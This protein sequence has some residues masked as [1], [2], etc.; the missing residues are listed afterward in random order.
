M[1]ANQQRFAH[2]A[3]QDILLMQIMLIVVY[4]L[5]QLNKYQTIKHI[6]VYTA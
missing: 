4:H 5:A 6:S 3:A 2:N 1:P